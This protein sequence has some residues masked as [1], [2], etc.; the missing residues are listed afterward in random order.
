[1]ENGKEKLERSIYSLS[2]YRKDDKKTFLDRA[3]LLD[4][5]VMKKGNRLITDLYVKLKDT[6]QYIH[7]SCITSIIIKATAILIKSYVLKNLLCKDQF[8]NE[9]EVWMNE[10]REKLV[11]KQLVKANKITI[12]SE[13]SK[14]QKRERNESEFVFN[15]TY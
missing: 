2:C 5:T 6:H 1:M 8:L 15:V 9:L 13:H 14:K 11:T 12:K 10:Q 3:I 4:V 7:G